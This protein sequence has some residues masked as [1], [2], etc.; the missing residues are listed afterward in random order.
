M[1]GNVDKEIFSLR[2]D[3]TIKGKLY[4]EYMN[5]EKGII[6]ED[7]AENEFYHI[8]KDPVLAARI[9]DICS[10]IITQYVNTTE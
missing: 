8:P 9:L 3:S 6:I 10:H 4:I 5:R 7:V 1:K 2:R